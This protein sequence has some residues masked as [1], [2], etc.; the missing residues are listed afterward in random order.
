MPAADTR[1]A[2]REA[3]KKK[4]GGR[5]AVL[6]P[7]G[8]LVVGGTGL[9]AV[10]VGD[11]GGTPASCESTV[12][13][14]VATTPELAAALEEKP[15]SSESCVRLD[16]VEQSSAE[17][18]QRAKADQLAEPLWIPDST[19]RVDE[20]GFDGTVKTH[21][22]S[23]ASSPAAVVSRE[24][25]G[26]LPDTWTGLL[27]DEST[28]MGDPGT[29]GGALAAMQS[30]AAEALSGIADEE[31]AQAVLTARAQT[32]DVT[33]PLLAT[34]ELISA[35]EE[36]GGRSIVAEHTLLREDVPSDLSADTPDSGAS[37]LD[38]PLMITAGPLSSSDSVQ[39]AAEEVAAWF[40]S[41]QGRRALADAGLRP[42]DGTP[43]D[44]DRSVEIPH[45]LQIED[46]AA[47]DQVAETYTR[48]SAPLNALVAVDA[49]GSMG[50]QEDGQTRWEGTMGTLT[51]GSQLFPPRDHLGLWLFSHD[52][53]PNGEPYRVLEPV[54]GIEEE[55]PEEDGRTQRQLIQEAATEADYKEG[56]QTALYETTLAA[57]RQQQENWQPGQL[58]AVIILSDGGQQV[59]G[60]EDP[61]RIEDLVSSLQE[62][63][64]PAK[65]VR[66]V[67][68]GISE[69]ADEVAL[70]AIA[71]AT[72]GSYHQATDEQELQT[73]F[74]EGLS[75]VDG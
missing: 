55:V 48:Q 10:T 49:S 24:G 3:E 26:D 41:D 74:V 23:V 63:Q 71:G 51:I 59:S 65:P 31:E 2:A 20:S 57:F 16:V 75:T 64:D 54:R 70:G 18:A 61:M 12:R 40:D 42:A 9:W 34:S 68:L 43:I 28:R 56:G 35:V 5:W 6:G 11:T 37:F 19:G 67:T 69:D 39:T 7:V 58:N 62:E 15:V 52:M 32:Q 45:R 73:A 25:S 17:T 44:D 47:W 72:G 33:T 21:T 13:I 22:S 4:S 66:I 53:G 30:A 36:D 1:R 60:D 8:L 50:K 38:Y 14:A 27:E 29:D 46:H